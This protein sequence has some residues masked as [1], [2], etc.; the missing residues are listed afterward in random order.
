[1]REGARKPSSP[2]NQKGEVPRR[3]PPLSRLSLTSQTR[4]L[5][6]FG[7]ERKPDT[8]LNASRSASL[9]EDF[10]EIR[11]RHV[12]VRTTPPRAVEEVDHIETNLKVRAFAESE[13]RPLDE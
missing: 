4:E 5:V 1:M 13:V 9:G 11:T 8:Q 10:T 6:D 3:A 2:Q 7:L 12:R